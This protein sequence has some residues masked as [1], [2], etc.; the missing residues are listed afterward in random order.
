MRDNVRQ[1]RRLRWNKETS[2]TTSRCGVSPRA[3]KPPPLLCLP[4]SQWQ[5]RELMEGGETGAGD[6]PDSLTEALGPCQK[7]AGCDLRG[8]KKHLTPAAAIR[9]R[10]R[11][12]LRG[13]GSE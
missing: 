4:A 7:P 2:G 6:G 1:L 10:R 12:R 8:R 9:P 11:N 3:C 5:G 13:K